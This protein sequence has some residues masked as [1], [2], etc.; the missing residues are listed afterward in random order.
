MERRI[1]R[2]EVEQKIMKKLVEIVDVYM[3]Y[4]P[5]GK[6]LS[7]FWDNGHYHVDNGTDS[8]QLDCWI[9]KDNE[10]EIVSFLKDGKD[11]KDARIMRFPFGTAEE[12]GDERG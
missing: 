11:G 6:Y 4:C 1:S 8:K 7:L 5:D 2:F 12:T 9:S 10:R 3:D